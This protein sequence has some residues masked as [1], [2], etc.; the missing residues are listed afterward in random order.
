MGKLLFLDTET[1]PVQKWED[2]TSQMQEAF[3]NHYYDEDEGD[4]L[5]TQYRRKA[6]LI[7]E[8]ARIICCS[9]GYETQ[10]GEYKFKAFSGTDEEA[11]LTSIDKIANPM[12]EAGYGIGGWNTNGFDIPLIAK[13]FVI[14]DDFV[15]P[16]F[17]VL[18]VKPWESR[19]VDVMQLWKMGGYKSSSLE[20]ACAALN[21]PVKFT[22]HTGKN[23]W[24]QQLEDIDWEELEMYCNN[25]VYSAYHVYKRLIMAGYIG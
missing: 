14:N 13:R 17:N 11:I 23:I 2:L 1:F 20:V 18:G 5:E 8:F 22:E 15:P 4:D 21:I 16:M 19:H 7:P 9:I 24:E 25:D 10:L 6:G 3:K 12:Y